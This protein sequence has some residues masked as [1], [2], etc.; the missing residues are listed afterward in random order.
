MEKFD[1]R[2]WVLDA[3]KEAI[4]NEP[5]FKTRR[6]AEKYY[7]AGVLTEEDMAEIQRIIEA[8]NVAEEELSIDSEYAVAMP[9]D[10]EEPVT[11]LT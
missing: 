6:Y 11:A 5:I 7:E 1:L 10:F 4:G 2:T 3:F 8:Y 9:E